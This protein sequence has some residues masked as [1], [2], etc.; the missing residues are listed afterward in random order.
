MCR[1]L[2]GCGLNRLVA[3]A[4]D[5]CHLKTLYDAMVL[6]VSLMLS[7]WNAVFE[8]RDLSDNKFTH[9]GP[10][11]LTGFGGQDESKVEPVVFGEISM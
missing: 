4:F 6:R 8:K 5:H 7:I 10:N 2:R 1:H 9:I 3:H 11:V